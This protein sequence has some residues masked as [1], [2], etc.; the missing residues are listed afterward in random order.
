MENRPDEF[1]WLLNM[2]TTKPIIIMKTTTALLIFGIYGILTGLLL[3]FRAAG[4][5]Q[6]YGT[7]NADA[8]HIAIVQFLGIT[9][10]GLGLLGVMLRKSDANTIK[11]YWTA[12]AFVTL[13]SVL[14]SVYDIA[15][16]GLVAS[17]FFYID[18]TIRGLVGLVCVYY[19]LKK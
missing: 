9:D 8:Y 4:S 1:R 3:L 5:L 11:S 16:V 15:V 2:L 14:K 12:G 13:G 10:I 17:D 6:D 7:P 18:M 19:A